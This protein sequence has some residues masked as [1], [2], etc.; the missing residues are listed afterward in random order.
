MLIPSPLV[1][2]TIPA[3]PAGRGAIPQG[4]LV[5]LAIDGEVPVAVGHHGH[6]AR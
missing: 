1:A 6:I 4:N 3:G 5:V 2:E